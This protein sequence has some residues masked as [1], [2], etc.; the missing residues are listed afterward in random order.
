LTNKILLT[1]GCSFTSPPWSWPSHVAKNIN[2]RL[3]NEGQGGSG[4]GL[5]KKK[6]LYR[7]T[8]LLKTVDKKDILVGVMWSGFT[9]H[10]IFTQY[11]IDPKNVSKPESDIIKYI[12]DKNSSGKWVIINQGWG[13]TYAKNFYLHFDLLAGVIQTLENILALQ[14]FLDFHKINYFMTTFTSE[15][16]P[17]DLINHPE[18]KWLHNQINFDKFLPVLGEYEWCA[19]VTTTE[20]LTTEWPMRWKHPTMLEHQDFSDNVII[21]YLKDKKLI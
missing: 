18:A 2:Y 7:L 11:P 19:G 14:N 1:G 4:N 15:T 9:R 12:D 17:Q 8:E 16:L 5:I 13:D 10:E 6:I 20:Q 3:I 21:P